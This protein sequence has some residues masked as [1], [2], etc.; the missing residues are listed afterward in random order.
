[1]RMNIPLHLCAHAAD[2]MHNDYLPKV[3]STKKQTTKY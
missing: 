3:I 1:M 2:R